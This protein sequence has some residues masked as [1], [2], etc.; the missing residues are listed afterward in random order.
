MFGKEKKAKID[1]AAAIPPVQEPSPEPTS[2]WTMTWARMK[3][4]KADC[5]RKILEAIGDFEKATGLL[6]TDV[7]FTTSIAEKHPRRSDDLKVS[8]SKVNAI[9]IVASLP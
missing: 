2:P 6:A 1:A 4:E 5:E 7:K 3:V 9:V 8:L